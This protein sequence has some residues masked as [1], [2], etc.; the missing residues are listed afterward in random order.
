MWVFKPEGLLKT[1]WHKGQTRFFFTDF[2]DIMIGWVFLLFIYISSEYAMLLLTQLS[3]LMDIGTD[4]VF[5]ELGSF[6]LLSYPIPLSITPIT[7]A[8]LVLGA[9]L[10]A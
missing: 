7:V 8:F 3:A 6:M 5:T 2:D 9:V 10:V 1:L 4:I